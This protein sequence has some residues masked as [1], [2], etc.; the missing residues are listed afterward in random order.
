MAQY[1]A[2]NKEA[3]R[4]REASVVRCACGSRFAGTEAHI[5]VVDTNKGTWTNLPCPECALKLKQ[6]A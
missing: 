3:I 4:A 1:L 5:Q 2:C 6:K